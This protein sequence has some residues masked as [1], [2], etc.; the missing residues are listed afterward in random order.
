MADM[1]DIYDNVLYYW[2]PDRFLAT[3]LLD[4]TEQYNIKLDRLAAA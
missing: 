3:A 4:S 2:V 1:A